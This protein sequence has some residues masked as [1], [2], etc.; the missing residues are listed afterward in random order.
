MRRSIDDEIGAEA[1]ALNRMTWRPING[2][3]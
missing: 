1:A 2:F 3:A